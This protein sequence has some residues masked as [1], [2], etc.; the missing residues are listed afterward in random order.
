MKKI[1]TLIILCILGLGIFLYNTMYIPTVNF[2]IGTIFEVRNSEGIRSISYRL[3]Q[4]GY[5][6]SALLFRLLLTAQNKDKSIVSGLYVFDTF[7]NEKQI[8]EKFALGK[9]DMPA[10]VVTI[11]EGFTLDQ[12]AERIEKLTGIKKDDF[13]LYAAKYEGR[14]FPETYYFSIG[15][16]TED[17]VTRMLQ[18]FEN[19]VGVISNDDLVLASIIEGEA[20]SLTDM[21][22]IAG[23]LKER[24]R[25]G[26]PLQVDVATSTYSVYGVPKI[27]INNPGL[28][29]IEAVRNPTATKYLY[30]LT[31]TDGKMYYAKTFKDHKANIQKYL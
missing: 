2:P 18:E 20:Q 29:A 23:I 5:I 14:L 12:I 28:N 4:S 6:K 9:Y 19:R 10:V 21:K 17:I 30:Y 7:M 22:I 31:G 8:A 25:I 3:K 15:E 24:L 27:P 1:R 16:E 11:P 13:V 26:M